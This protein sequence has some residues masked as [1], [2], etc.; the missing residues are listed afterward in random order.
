MD[1]L[2]AQPEEVQESRAMFIELLQD[3]ELVALNTLCPKTEQRKAT[4][5]SR[6]EHGRTEPWIRPI[7]EVIDYALIELR[8][9]NAVRDV[10]TYP[11][12][13]IA[14]DHYPMKIK[15]QVRLKAKEE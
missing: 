12:A 10:E 9:R 5:L 11:E 14:S 1:T 2:D 8:W 6:K 15:M 13:N 4:F 7:H 3:K